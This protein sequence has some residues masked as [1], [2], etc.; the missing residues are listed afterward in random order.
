[1]KTEPHYIPIGTDSIVRIVDETCQNCGGTYI[2][3]NQETK[4]VKNRELHDQL[5]IAMGGTP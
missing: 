2:N 1:M 4:I 5:I 3:E